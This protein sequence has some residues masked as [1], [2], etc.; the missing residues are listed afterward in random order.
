MRGDRAV[1]PAA[2]LVE[3]VS[4]RAASGSEHR[5]RASLDRLQ[6]LGEAEDSLS[7]VEADRGES[8]ADGEDVAL[9]SGAAEAFEKGAVA[10]TDCDVRHVTGSTRLRSATTGSWQQ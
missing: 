2:V 1:A 4:P 9:F 6:I 8:L 5:G 10:S 7:V 3:S